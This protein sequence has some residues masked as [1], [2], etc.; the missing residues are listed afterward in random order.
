MLPNL[1]LIQPLCTMLH[2][3]FSSVLRQI[4]TEEKKQTGQM[5]QTTAPFG[6]D[7]YI[8]LDYFKYSVRSVS[9]RI[10]PYI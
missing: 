1:V 9:H 7:K 4:Y 5:M 8:L 3:E 10:R 6:H 2:I